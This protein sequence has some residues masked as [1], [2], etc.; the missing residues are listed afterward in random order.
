MV[1]IGKRIE[2]I[3]ETY[4][5]TQEELGKVLH[6]SASSISHYER[7]DWFIPMKNLYMMANYLEL[8]IDYILGLT[9]IKQ[10]SSYL[11]EINLQRIGKR[12]QE[13]CDEQKLSNV[14]LGKILNTSESNIRNYKT[15]KYLILTPFV[16][17]LSL[18]YNYSVDWIVGRSNHKYLKNEKIAN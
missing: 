13:I 6:I 5:L 7:N 16:I 10:Y 17:Q 8:S 1:N 2:F 3:R 12:I 15:G 11:P 18:K 4:D 14:K 9:S